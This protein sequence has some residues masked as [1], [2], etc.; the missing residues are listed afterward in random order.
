MTRKIFTYL[1]LFYAMSFLGH[2]GMTMAYG[3][4]PS[5]TAAA[6][7]V[8]AG[9]VMVTLWKAAGRS[10]GNKEMVWGIFSGFFLW[11]FFGE[12]LEHEGIIAL[13]AGRAA[14]L[15]VPG[16]LLISYLIYIKYAPIGTRFAL[17]HFGCVWLLH[18]ILVNQEEVVKPH[19][20]ALSAI[21]LPV[22]GLAFFLIALFMFF[23]TVRA[24]SE[25]TLLA[26]LLPS[27]IFF[28]AALETLQVMDVLP[29]Y[30]CYAYWTK[31]SSSGPETGTWE[32]GVNNKI[33]LLKGRY[34]WKDE[35]AEKHAYSLLKRLPSP[36]FIDDFTVRLEEQMKREGKKH[37]NE[38][39]FYRVMEESFAKTTESAFDHLLKGQIE[40]FKAVPSQD[41]NRPMD[42]AVYHGRNSPRE[43]VEG[44]IA[45]IKERYTWET[46][47]TRELAGYLLTRFSL[48]FLTGDTFIK[49][50][51]E[52][53]GQEKTGI[54]SEAL[55]CRVMQEYFTA[56]SRTVFNN[57]RKT[58]IEQPNRKGGGL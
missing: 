45:I 10:Q 4:G 27:F 24:G 20:P 21:I 2:F 14:A 58:Y 13:A 1:A 15:L 3:L 42:Y 25:R 50:L 22:T 9:A 37:M 23:K 28:W 26:Y 54:L 32:E 48:Q 56:T 52:K 46:G 40:Q 33:A 39:L 41:K 31:G 18:A 55:L 38:E 51:D 5:G 6:G 36:R 35:E 30:T 17:F 53:L 11:C 29:D 34:P 7:A 19:Y 47:Q 57:L 49:K 8:L 43:D 12:F 44:K 16:L